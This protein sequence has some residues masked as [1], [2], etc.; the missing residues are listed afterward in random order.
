MKSILFLILFL[1]TSTSLVFSQVRKEALS[2]QTYAEELA[3]ERNEKEN[4]DSKDSKRMHI[5]SSVGILV[6]NQKLI[7]PV[8]T[9]KKKGF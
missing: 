4:D 7:S 2:V 1:L 9:L 3:A 6:K 8:F 5:F